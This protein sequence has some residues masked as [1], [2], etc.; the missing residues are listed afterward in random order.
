[1]GRHG[2]ENQLW[3]GLIARFERVGAAKGIDVDA[4]DV[5]ESISKSSARKGIGPPLIVNSI[6]AP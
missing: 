5:V 2:C 1:M 4:R 3:H 6:L